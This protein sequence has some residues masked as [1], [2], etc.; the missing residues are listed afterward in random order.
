MGSIIDLEGIDDVYR[1][2]SVK[3]TVIYSTLIGVPLSLI[4]LIILIIRIIFLKKIKTFQ[5]C[6]ILLILSSEIIQC[7][8][9]ILQLIKYSFEDKRD[10]K[11]FTDLDT[12]RGIIC[13]IQIVFALYSDFSSFLT[14]LLLTL[15]FYEDLR[16][17]EKF[18]EKKRNRI[19][20]ILFIICISIIISIEFLFFDRKDSYNNTSYRFDVRDRCTYGCWLSHIQSI[21]CS[22]LYWIFIIINTI[23]ACKTNYYLKSILNSSK[24]ED[25]SD[26]SNEIEENNNSPNELDDEKNS[27]KKRLA[28]LNL[29]RIKCIIY[30]IIL[31]IFWLLISIYRTFDD[32]IMIRFD[33]GND[34]DKGENE[35]KEFFTN[36]TFLQILVQLFLVIY[37]VLSSLRGIIYGLSFIIFEEEILYDFFRKNIIY[38]LYNNTHPE[39]KEQ[40]KLLSTTNYSA[41]TENK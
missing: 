22:G 13:Q 25:N 21:I 33:R 40:G 35:E 19:V 24:E 6:L 10:D 29:L 41:M 12:E 39:E 4:F 8:S 38:K 26:N 5:T 30:P 34:P 2:N 31:I 11:S 37:A 20:S 15:K 28:E 7:L 36:N 18:L 14:I 3:S 23:F 1:C 17:I 16:N 9:K 27:E 32:F